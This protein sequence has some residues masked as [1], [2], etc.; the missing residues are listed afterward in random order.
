[1]EVIASCPKMEEEF[2]TTEFAWSV[3]LVAYP[4]I[5]SLIFLNS[6]TEKEYR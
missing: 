6:G 3:G 1:M 5:L 4:S 2:A